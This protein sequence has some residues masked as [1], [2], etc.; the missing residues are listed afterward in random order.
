MPEE[1]PSRHPTDDRSQTEP[2]WWDG[3]APQTLEGCGVGCLLILFCYPFL[4]LVTSDED[5]EFRIQ[6][7]DGIGLIVLICVMLAYEIQWAGQLN[8]VQQIWI[9]PL[10]GLTCG[11]LLAIV[12]QKPV[13]FLVGLNFVPIWWLVAAVVR[14]YTGL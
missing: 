8:F 11:G 7:A 12:R 2:W 13:W 5:G 10:I 9:S 14:F 1:Q 6:W 4:K 3:C